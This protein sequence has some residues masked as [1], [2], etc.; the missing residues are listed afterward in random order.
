MCE[1]VQWHMAL[2]PLMGVYRGSIFIVV[3]PTTMVLVTS[4]Y[5]VLEQYQKV[6]V[7]KVHPFLVTRLGNKNITQQYFK[8][9]AC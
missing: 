7:I 3:I 8:K 4:I 9:L 5:A 2:F 1:V 6:S